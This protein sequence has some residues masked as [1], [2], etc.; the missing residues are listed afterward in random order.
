MLYAVCCI[1]YAVYASVPG[2]VVSGEPVARPPVIGLC[3]AVARRVVDKYGNGVA[4]EQA[5]GLVEA[6]VARLGRGISGEAA[7]MIL[8]LNG[9]YVTRCDTHA[10]WYTRGHQFFFSFFSIPFY[11]IRPST[12]IRGHMAGSSSPSPLRFVL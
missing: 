8:Y 9:R 12:Q 1:L 3:A 10:A 11:D 7:S 2:R 4:E 6:I 5:G